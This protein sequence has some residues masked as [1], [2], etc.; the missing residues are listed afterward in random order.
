MGKRSSARAAKP[1]SP[2]WLWIVPLVGFLSFLVPYQRDFVL[3]DVE[4]VRD[5]PRI[6]SLSPAKIA[7]LF[8][9]DY[10]GH[11]EAGDHGLYRPLTLLSFAAQRA[12]GTRDATPFHVVNSLLHGMAALLLSWIV[13]RLGRDRGV[14]LGAGLLF[15]SHPLHTEAVAG[16]VGRAEILALLGILGSVAFLLRALDAS[17]PPVLLA[18][19]SALCAMAAA[20]SKETGFMALPITA[21][22]FLA[23]STGQTAEHRRPA[24]MVLAF[25]GVALAL[26][27]FLRHGAIEATG[28]HHAWAGVP[29]AQRVATALRVTREVLELQLVPHRF[30]ADYSLA[31]TPLASGFADFG[32]LASVLV[33]AALIALG[34]RLRRTVPLFGWGLGV[35]C[36]AY[37][38]VS[39]LLFPIGVIKAER[40]LYSPSAG[41]L[42][43]IAAAMALLV[44]RAG[45]DRAVVPAF[46]SLAAAFVLLTWKHNADWRDNCHLAAATVAVAPDSRVLGVIHGRCL[47]DAGQAAEA[48]AALERILVAEPAFTPAHLVLGDLD[49]REN[50]FAAALQH[51]F[52]VLAQEPHHP[53]A[54]S[55]ASFLC[56][57]TG[58]YSKAATLYRQRSLAAPHDPEPVAGLI[59]SLAL[60]GDIAAAEAA[61]QRGLQSFPG[62]A[63]IRENAAKLEQ[64]KSS[65]Q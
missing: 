60:T 15:A 7:A 9:D 5:N 11:I 51:M 29:P 3:D 21:F 14:A 32:V 39:N 63:N 1:R 61:A 13:L 46:A 2:S 34:W 55:Q 37:A 57:Q 38:P 45:L 30:C 40:L 59:A 23:R 49:R 36:I 16:I 41:F 18:I 27:Y 42:V 62:D 28:V 35:F 17:R 20:L 25:Q 56:Y 4:I 8:T 48:R 6:E 47:A 10:W 44:R 26:A 43:T 52:E 22:T 50:N 24:A 58:D 65:P 12:S 33:V 64:L 54:L 53:V 31:T 19:A